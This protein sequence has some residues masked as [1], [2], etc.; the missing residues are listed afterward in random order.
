MA[1]EQEG[2]AGLTH[3]LERLR[4]SPFSHKKPK[5]P[6]RMTTATQTCPS[7]HSDS[8]ELIGDIPHGYVFAG[9]P[10]E[11]PLPGGSLFRCQTCYVGFK[12]PQLPKHELN[13]YYQAAEFA[14]W[15]Y[16]PESRPDWVAAR[17][18]LLDGRS[19]GSLLDVGCF[20]GAFLNFVNRD[21]EAWQLFGIE[22]NSEAARVAQ[23]AGIT[24]VGSDADEISGGTCYDAIVAFDIIEHLAAPVSFLARLSELLKP[25]GKLVLSTGN[26]DSRSW[27]LM[28]GRYWYCALPE[29]LS[30]L[31]PRW[32]RAVAAQCGLTVQEIRYFSHASVRGLRQRLPETIKNL[33]Y[34]FAPSAFRG[35]RRKGWGGV[36]VAS[37]PDLADTPPIWIT[38]EDQF[39]VV[40]EKLHQS[41]P[42]QTT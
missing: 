4:T 39:L 41:T 11:S 42:D 2:H 19:R 40:F 32:S 38:A 7:C 29:H 3:H 12:W 30:F 17:R 5:A 15:T 1:V 16:D 22:L 36:D 10:L 18:I 27:R 37:S 14:V 33:L 20:D 13:E 28:G 34:R 25:G 21:S 9:R 24:M 35:L 23:E 26:L 8:T 31:S 6:Q